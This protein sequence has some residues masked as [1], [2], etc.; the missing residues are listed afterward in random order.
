[1]IDPKLEQDRQNFLYKTAQ[2]VSFNYDKKEFLKNTWNDL[3]AQYGDKIPSEKLAEIE[4]ESDEV[5]KILSLINAARLLN[6]NE[7]DFSSLGNLEANMQAYQEEE[8]RQAE[9][10]AQ[11]EVVKKVQNNPHKFVQDYIQTITAANAK[12]DPEMT[13]YSLIN[14]ER[15]PQTV[16]QIASF[17]DSTSTPIET[18][19]A[20]APTITP[21]VENN[22]HPPI[23]YVYKIIESL[24]PNLPPIVSTANT[25][26]MF[27]TPNATKSNFDNLNH[28]LELKINAEGQLVTIPDTLSKTVSELDA[29]PSPDQL[30]AQTIAI[31]LTK[32]GVPASTVQQFKA[33]LPLLY[34]MSSYA[35][36]GKKAQ[37]FASFAQIVLSQYGFTGPKSYQNIDF[38]WIYLATQN[39]Y[40]PDQT[41]VSQ[42]QHLTPGNPFDNQVTRF[43]IDQGSGW[44]KENYISPLAAEA[45]SNFAAS[46]LGQALG[47]GAKAAVTTGVETAAA[48]TAAVGAGEVAAGA[49]AGTGFAATITGFLTALGIADP[50]PITKVIIAILAVLSTQIKNIVSWLKKQTKN[51]ILLLGG[52]I[53]IL[54]AA[55]GAAFAGIVGLGV[56]G[57]VVGA[58]VGAVGFTA[59]TGGSKPL[60]VAASKF[61]TFTGALVGLVAVEIG[62]T[63][64]I[65]A[66]SIPIVIALILFIIN[67]SALVVPPNMYS[68]S[69]SA[70]L[71]YTGP[72]PEGCPMI[73]P[74]NNS[75][76]INQG[77]WVPASVYPNASHKNTEAID[78]GVAYK[79][80]VATHNGIAFPKVGDGGFATYG[81]FVDVY[82]TCNYKNT[83]L[84]IISR[85][86]HLSSFLVAP[87]TPVQKG[88]P[89][90][91]SGNSGGVPLHLHYEFRQDN[92]SVY[93]LATNLQTD[94]A[95]F[96]WPEFIPPSPLIPRGCWS[97]NDTGAKLPCNTIIP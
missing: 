1:M 80:V 71:A 5:L 96:M 53:A 84:R 13:A 87:N 51:L 17:V 3:L 56:A 88:Q 27:D 4:K 57:A 85:Y 89:I 77:A 81:N 40:G 36:S 73:W 93:G 23:T 65:I 82:S 47:F 92:G 61:T 94:T 16:S 21:L 33:S 64:I 29:K 76:T 74:V 14:D 79:Q 69:S 54:G 15:A 52:G 91:I 44:V 58:G 2:S 35:P 49:A 62:T 34:S 7:N 48:T 60:S 63:V 8:K 11:A 32:Q 75:A 95:P 22:I 43:F 68:A 39:F 90:A 26:L 55:L 86:S 6:P 12:I 97:Y 25:W 83:Q 41:Y 45:F 28:E 38:S 10:L 50:E 18:A 46:G 37:V 66:I 70:N 31:G 24:T 9:Q 59:L 78:I 42:F 72:L 67:T 19:I 20:M 30:F